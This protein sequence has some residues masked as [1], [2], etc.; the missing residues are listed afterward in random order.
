MGINYIH[1]FSSFFILSQQVK[2]DENI[3][4]IKAA[5]NKK[6][7]DLEGA[8]DQCLDAAAHE[9]DYGAQK[10]LL[11]AASFGK[12]SCEEYSADKFVD[13]I[14]I[15]RVLNAIRHSSVGVPLTF[16]QYSK[17]E[18]E[19]VVDRLINRHEHLLALRICEYL[20]MPLHKVI[21]L[22]LSSSHFFNVFVWCRFSSIGHAQR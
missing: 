3:R 11:K 2:A 4:S 6:G 22:F 8:I 18:A 5:G 16:E 20:Q 14:R 17:L 21:I 7:A 13:M 10:T 1:G 15:L 9:F 19:V 12:L